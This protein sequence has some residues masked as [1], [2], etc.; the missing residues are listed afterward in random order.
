VRLS[1]AIELLARRLGLNRGRTATV[2]NRLQHAGRLPLADDKRNPPEISADDMA[3][4]IIAV[5]AERGIGGAAERAVQYAAMTGAGY[6]LHES[7]TAIMRGNTQSGD[8]IV[9]EG[10]VSATVGGQHVV[11]GAPVEDGFARFATGPTLSAIAAE[12]QG[13]SPT[14]ADA[15]AAITRINYGN[16][17]ID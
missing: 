1:E 17:R 16:N 12:F 2:A 4:L 11:F 13:W 10:G 6:G 7:A 9:K 5:L 15:A 3:I 8:M 14:Q